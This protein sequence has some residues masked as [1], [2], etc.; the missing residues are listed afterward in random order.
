MSILLLGNGIN[1][2]E[3]LTPKW[4]DLVVDIGKKY[5][6][7]AEKSLSNILGYE[8]LENQII[9]KKN[10]KNE[11]P[12]HKTIA[13]RTESDAIKSRRNWNNTIHSKLI[14]LPIRKILTTNY[15]YAI[16]RS[17]EAD[18]V[19]Q[20]NTNE[21]TYSLQRYQRAAGRTVFHI[22]GECNY[23]KS[24]CLG[25][26]Q[27]AGTLQHIRNKIVKRT[28]K[29]DQPEYSFLLADILNGLTEQ[30]INSWIYDFFKEDIFILGLSLDVSEMDLWWLLSYRSK[31][32]TSKKLPISNRIVFLD[33]GSDNVKDEMPSCMIPSC[34]Y[35]REAL[36]AK[37]L[38]RRKRK[39]LLESFDVEYRMCKG[40]SFRDQYEDALRFLKRNTT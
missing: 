33:T 20:K 1:L 27:Y 14:N 7:K 2:L 18:F 22:H 19:P 15:D 29:K 13:D 39:S 40:D 12:I 32:L 3:E 25:Y 35:K 4:E 31:Q 36:G 26:E 23:P 16:E 34:F 24:I 6:C 5:G 9:K 10:L 21:T 30:P 8:M 38:D 17:A 37:R 28:A 11:F